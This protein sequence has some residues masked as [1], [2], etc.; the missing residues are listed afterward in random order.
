MDKSF[1]DRIQELKESINGGVEPMDN[2]KLSTRTVKIGLGMYL[3]QSLIVALW[4]SIKD[5]VFY[6]WLFFISTFLQVGWFWNKV[7]ESWKVARGYLYVCVDQDEDHSAMDDLDPANFEPY[8]P[9][10]INVQNDGITGKNNKSIAVPLDMQR[11]RESVIDISTDKS[12]VADLAREPIQDPLRNPEL[13][14]DS[15]D[16]RLWNDD[17]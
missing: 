13:L 1:W 16:S 4:W 11:A 7:T 6:P 3:L 8:Y 12:S 5:G 9:P 2:V 10:T 17:V 15:G 14:Q